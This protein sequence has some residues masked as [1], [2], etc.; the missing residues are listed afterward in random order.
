MC[1]RLICSQKAFLVVNILIIASVSCRSLSNDPVT[2]KFLNLY[3]YFLGDDDCD[4]EQIDP[5]DS[6]PEY[7]VFDCLN[8]EEVEK[9]LNESV[10]CL[11]NQL[12]ITPSL[13]KVLLH[14]HK[15]N[16]NEVIEKYRNNAA[17]LL[18]GFTL[19]GP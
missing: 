14:Q 7:F 15:W 10:E 13:A 19:K 8:T 2:Q 9:L 17:G 11:S 3:F 5:R 16:T 6:D 18:V 4:I 12:Q 1:S